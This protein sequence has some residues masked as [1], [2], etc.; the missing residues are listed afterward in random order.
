MR[1]T[2]LL[3]NLA[4]DLQ[5]KSLHQSRYLPGQNSSSTEASLHLARVEVCLDIKKLFFSSSI[6]WLSLSLYS[7]HQFLLQTKIQ[8]KLQYQASCHVSSVE[9]PAKK[10]SRHYLS[11]E[12]AHWKNCRFPCPSLPKAKQFSRRLICSVATEPFPKQ[13]EESKMD[14]PKEIFLK[15]YKLPDYY[16]CMELLF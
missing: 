14:M 2:Y 13:V 7:P 12:V 10:F 11:L 4:K 15:D 5:E 6:Q 3:A 1:Q 9:N 16:F 8:H